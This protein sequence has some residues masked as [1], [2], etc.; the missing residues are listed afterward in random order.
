[1]REI[2]GE[3]VTIQIAKRSELYTFTVMPKRSI[4]ERNFAWQRRT[5]GY[6]RTANVNS[7]PACSSFIWPSWHCYSEDLKQALGRESPQPHATHQPGKDLRYLLNRVLL[8]R[9]V[10]PPNQ[11]FKDETD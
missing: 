9:L 7:R 2:L 6:G 8:R 10:K 4:V 11:R 5:D 1:M 3:A